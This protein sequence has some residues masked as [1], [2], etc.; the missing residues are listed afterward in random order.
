MGNMRRMSRVDVHQHLWPEPFLAALA[1]RVEP[2]FLRRAPGGWTLRLAGEA[3]CFVDPSAHDTELRRAQLRADG[4]DRALLCMSSP[5]GVE[6]LPA[7]EARPLLDAWHEGVLGLGEAFGVWGAVALDRPQTADVDA[8]LGAGAVGISLPAAAICSPE[9]LR[10]V[11]PLLERIE[12][13]DAPLLVHPGP[14]SGPPVAGWWPALTSYVAEMHA[15]W[16]AFVAAGRLAH[17]GLKVAFAMLAGG[18]PLHLERM[19]ARG[20]PAGRGLDPLLFY[21]TS[22]YGPRAVDAVVRVVG[23]DQLLAGSDRP[24]VDAP[25]GTQLGP[26]AREAMTRANPP[27]CWSAS[28]ATCRWR[29]DPLPPRSHARRGG[30]ARPRRVGRRPARPVGGARA[31]RRAGPHLQAARARRARRGLAHLLDGGPR[32]G[33][34]RP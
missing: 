12:S 4:F 17:P 11:A 34:P 27:G 30:A 18:A 13:W 14:A 8:L 2:P 19:A 5:L 21:D 10:S 16:M 33:L 23:I 25:P 15:A 22:S 28:A 7:A 9:R 26:A 20:G 31:P 3:D 29:H 32:H 24:V 1:R 6:S